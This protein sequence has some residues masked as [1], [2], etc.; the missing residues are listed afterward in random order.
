MFAGALSLSLVPAC[1]VNQHDDALIRMTCRDFVRKQLH[2]LGIDVRQDQPIELASAD[3]HHP[4][5]IGILV[6]QHGLADWAYWLGNPAPAHVRDALHKRASSWNI[7][8]MALPCAQSWRISATVL[9]EF[10]P[11]ILSLWIALRTALVEGDFSP[12]EAVQQVVG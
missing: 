10:F 5:G 7:S 12:V 2:A 8:L 3:I 4:I 6:R 11:L 1:T 9:G